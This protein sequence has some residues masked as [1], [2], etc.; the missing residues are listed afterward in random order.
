MERI[1]TKFEKIN[2]LKGCE[3]LDGE[4]RKIRKREKKDQSVPNQGKLCHT[5]RPRD[6]TN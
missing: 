6:S 1:E 2:K 4:T 5:C 3:I